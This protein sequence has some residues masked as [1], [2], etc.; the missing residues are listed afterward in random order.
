MRE[1]LK[2]WNRLIKEDIYYEPLYDPDDHN[3]YA[4]IYIYNYLE[5]HPD[6]ERKLFRAIYK[7]YFLPLYKDD[8]FKGLLNRVIYLMKKENRESLT[9][10]EFNEKESLLDII[11]N[12]LF[13]S[14]TG[15]SQ[16]IWHKSLISNLLNKML[17]DYWAPHY[18]YMDIVLIY[19]AMQQNGVFVIYKKKLIKTP[20]NVPN[21]NLQANYDYIKHKY[22]SLK[23]KDLENVDLFSQYKIESKLGEGAFGTVYK[24]QGVNRAIKIFDSSISLQKD[25]DRFKQIEDDLFSGKGVITDMPYF[26]SGRLGKSDYYYAVMP[27]IVPIQNTNWYRLNDLFWERVID[28]IEKLVESSTKQQPLQRYVSSGLEKFLEKERISAKDKEY[29]YLIMKAFLEAKIKWKGTDLHS[30]N[31]GF[32]PQSPDI[33]FF[34]DM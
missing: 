1:L 23:I 22:I 11:A 29:A 3:L 15:E 5:S 9:N 31:I 7:E 13:Y 24:F 25:L 19:K 6:D 32:L 14:Q 20:S 16:I 8:S 2:E 4:N 28:Q 27:T 12:K 18:V 34:F 33:F 30:G 21:Y 17:F 10:Q 26:E